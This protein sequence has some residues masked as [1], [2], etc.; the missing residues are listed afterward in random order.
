MVA[1]RK[2]KNELVDCDPTLFDQIVKVYNKFPAEP[3]GSRFYL[4]W[5]EIQRKRSCTGL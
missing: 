1:R 5:A 2:E 4:G 3:E